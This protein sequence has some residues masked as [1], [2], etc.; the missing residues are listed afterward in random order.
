MS[1]EKSMKDLEDY[2][3]SASY[4][5]DDLKAKVER[6]IESYNE[7]ADELKDEISTLESQNEKLEEE[8]EVSLEVIRALQKENLMLNIELAEVTGQL[9][10][11]R[12]EK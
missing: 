9:I 3:S 7:F 11:L 10:Q 1:L 12:H 8:A 6:E 2:L 5:L 4:E